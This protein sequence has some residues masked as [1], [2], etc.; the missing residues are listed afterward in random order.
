MSWMAEQYQEQQEQENE[1]GIDMHDCWHVCHPL[2]EDE[3]RRTENGKIGKHQRIG[4]CYVEGS[5]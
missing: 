4:N 3:L 1:S 5:R 2:K